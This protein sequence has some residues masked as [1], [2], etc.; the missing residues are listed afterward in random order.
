LVELGLRDGL[1]LTVRNMAAPGWTIYQ[2]RL[3]V[4][5]RL[6][7][8]SE[9]P[10]LVIFYDGFNDAIGTVISSALTGPDPRVP[11]LFDHAE[12][13]AFT[14]SQAD[15]S[16]GGSPAELGRLS[17]GKYAWE[18]RAIA[19]L[20]EGLGIA[21]AFFFQPDAFAD[22]FQYE[23]VESVLSEPIRENREFVDEVLRM[24]SSELSGEVVNLRDAYDGQERPLFAD[25][26]HT[27]EEAAEISA[28]AVY[29][30]VRPNLL[31]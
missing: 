9:Q 13:Q 5:E 30:R 23:S 7:G 6:R 27:N 29:A 25:P 4:E 18:Q 28:A 26:V 17:A 10:D 3:A 2:E 14:N 16:Q 21:S 22:A 24:A 20:L 8:G 19:D 15:P 11:A 31:G 1:S 12:I